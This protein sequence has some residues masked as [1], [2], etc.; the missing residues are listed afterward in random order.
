MRG[1]CH[2]LILEDDDGSAD[3]VLMGVSQAGE[4]LPCHVA[5]MRGV[6]AAQMHLEPIVSRTGVP[7]RIRNCT[8]LADEPAEGEQ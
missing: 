7:V 3:I 8:M 1:T 2:W 4:E 5:R 6:S